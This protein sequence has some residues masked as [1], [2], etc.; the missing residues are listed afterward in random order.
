MYKYAIEAK[1][2][3][4]K[5]F[6]ISNTEKVIQYFT[7][8]MEGVSKSNAEIRLDVLAKGIMN[9]YFNGDKTFVKAKEE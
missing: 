6:G 8:R 7:E 5:Q 1:A 4:L 3:F 9:G 2:R